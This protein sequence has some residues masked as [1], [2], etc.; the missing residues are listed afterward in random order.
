MDKETKVKQGFYNN[1][2]NIAS[3][4]GFV[5]V[6]AILIS[7]FLRGVTVNNTLDA[8][9]DIMGLSISVGIYWLANRIYKA[10][11]PKLQFHELFENKLQMWADKNKYLIDPSLKE[12]KYYRVYK[13]VVDHKRLI[14]RKLATNEDAN[15]KANFIKLPLIKQEK[16]YN[17]IRFYL[18]N[19]PNVYVKSD[20]GITIK[21]IIESM[22]DN[23]RDEFKDSIA[24]T[25]F[26]CDP[27]K[28]E[29]IVD[30]TNID[31]TA[32]N[33]EQTIEKLMDLV[34]YVKILYLAQA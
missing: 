9:K 13:M 1:P 17:E 30:I 22:T 6:V 8:V 5:G 26:C 29:I 27:S 28:Y 18:S 20:T 3:L 23:I 21:Q 12:D 11:R 14:S 16:G 33:Q 32:A 4:L 24:G 2:D 19:S 31:K 7:L 15:K 10:K 34:D 25:S